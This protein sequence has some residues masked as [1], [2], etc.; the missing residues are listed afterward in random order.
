MKGSGFYPN[1][2]ELIVMTVPQNIIIFL[3][4]RF[5][6][7]LLFNYSISKVFR[8]YTFN[9]YFIFSLLEGN[10]QFFTYICSNQLQTFF[11]F[12]ISTKMSNLIF[13]LF[14]FMFIQVSFTIYF[15]LNYFYENKAIY[16]K[17]NQKD[18][19]YGLFVVTVVSSIRHI[20]I[21]AISSFCG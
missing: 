12:G 17:D 14:L 9:C 19:I 8:E 20:V 18:T 1:I 4:F 16:F 2:V 21:A 15:T 11:H 5:C 3:I 10:M 13:S 6:F 7:K